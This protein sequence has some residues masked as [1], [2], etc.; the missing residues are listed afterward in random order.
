MARGVDGFHTGQPKVPEQIW[1]QKGR[2]KA[3]AGSIYVNRNVESG[4]LLQAIKCGTQLDHIFIVTCKSA[5]QHRN[6]A[7][8]VLVTSGGSALRVG[9]H[10]ISLEGHLPG[11]HVPIAGKFMPADLGVGARHQVWLVS[12]VAQL[13]HPLAPTPLQG[14]AAQHACFAR[15]NGRRPDC[16]LRLRCMPQLS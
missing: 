7:N 8:G 15:S 4:L 3:A 11:F 16:A 14:E 10:L 12:S 5:A 9:G 1:L 13:A 6:D 2:N